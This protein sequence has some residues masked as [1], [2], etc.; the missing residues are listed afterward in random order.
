MRRF[1]IPIGASHIMPEL[2]EKKTAKRPVTE[3]R[4]S[5]RFSPADGGLAEG[6][7]VEGG[8]G[9]AGGG[10]EGGAGL[11]CPWSCRGRRDR[12]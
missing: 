9:F 1:S 4:H 2:L 11:N 12:R 10:E 6:A 8:D 3:G 5:D 7:R